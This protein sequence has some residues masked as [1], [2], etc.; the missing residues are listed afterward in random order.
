MVEKRECA[1][2]GTSWMPSRKQRR[3]GASVPDAGASYSGGCQRRVVSVLGRKCAR[4]L[5]IK[6]GGV[7]CKVRGVREFLTP[8]HLTLGSGCCGGACVPATRGQEHDSV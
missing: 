3:E 1:D 6:L 2:T 7:N 4:H 8:E 5:I